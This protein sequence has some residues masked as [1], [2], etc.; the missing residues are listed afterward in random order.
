MFNLAFL[1]K[2]HPT[3]KEFEALYYELNRR[4]FKEITFP[5]ISLLKYPGITS[6]EGSDLSYL[7]DK[8]L[9][10]EKFDTRGCR[11]SNLSYPTDS[12]TGKDFSNMSLSRCNFSGKKFIGCNFS[13]ANL[14]YSNFI[15]AIFVHC[16]FDNNTIAT[17]GGFE[18]VKVINCD[19]SVIN[20]DS[21]KAFHPNNQP[22]N[23]IKFRELTWWE[24]IYK[25]QHPPQHYKNKNS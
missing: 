2:K 10:I 23:I 4:S 15:R 17:R 19:L 7:I 11:V 8:D 3:L 21:Y 22:S 6:I 1:F 20:F 25:S 13:G 9:V 14:K 12:I 18:G 24:K 5:E 16:I